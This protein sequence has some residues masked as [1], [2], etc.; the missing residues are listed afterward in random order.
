MTTKLGAAPAEIEKLNANLA[1]IEALSQRLIAAVAQKRS[2]NPALEGP[3]QDL[4]T[5]AIKVW[6]GE[7]ISDPARMIEQQAS[8]WGKALEHYIAAQKALS[9][10]PFKAP[11]DPGP[12]DRRFANPMWQTH[13]YFNFIKQQYLGNVAA[14]E[15]AVLGDLPQPAQSAEGVVELAGQVIEHAT[16][17]SDRQNGGKG[18]KHSARPLASSV[19]RGQ[20]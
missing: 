10:G 11:D 15:T 20:S 14:M 3:G 17:L 5:K 6:W 9:E 19:P 16:T 18:E 1:R 12:T 7:A 4:M 13:P 8:Y 2:P